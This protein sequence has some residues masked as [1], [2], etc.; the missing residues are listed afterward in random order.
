MGASDGLL[1]R[2]YFG[3][4]FTGSNEDLEI[5][6]SSDTTVEGDEAPSDEETAGDSAEDKKEGEKRHQVENLEDVFVRVNFDATLLGDVLTNLKSL[7][8]QL[9]FKN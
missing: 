6:L 9:R 8:S 5:G 1:Y 7:K 3:R 2:L 4:A